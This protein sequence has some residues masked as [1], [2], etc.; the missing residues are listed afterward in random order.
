MEYYFD[1]TIKIESGFLFR[2]NVLT[3]KGG[4]MVPYKKG[5]MFLVHVNKVTTK[6][7]IKRLNYSL[8]AVLNKPCE[9]CAVAKLKQ[10]TSARL[11]LV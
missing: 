11:L 8:R 7:T 5:H 1:H 4:T 9:Y 3:G 10:K 6:A 2:L